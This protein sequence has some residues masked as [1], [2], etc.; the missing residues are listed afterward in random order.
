MTQRFTIGN[1]NVRNLVPAS[2]DEGYH[3]FY[4]ADKRNCYINQGSDKH[5]QYQ[6]KIAWLARQLD[7]LD[8]DIV[9]FEE[10]FE[11]QPLEDVVSASSYANKVKLYIC[12][13][14]VYRDETWEGKPARIHI[15]P[16]IALMV[17]NDFT[18]SAEKTIEK[19]SEQYDFSRGIREYSGRTWQ[20]QLTQGGKQINTFTHPVLRVV[21]KLPA[22]FNNVLGVNKGRP[23]IV[24][25]AAH[26]KSKRPIQADSRENDLLK[27]GRRYLGEHA[28][29]QARSLLVRAIEAAALRAYVL[30]DLGGKKDRPVFLLGDLNDGPRGITTDI[31]GGLAGKVIS[32]PGDRK[33]KQH[34]S[35]D[36]ALYSAYDLQT[37]KTHRD[38]YF[39]HIYEGFHDTLDHVMVSSHFVP[40]ALRNGLGKNNIGNV[41]TLRVLNDHLINA[42]VDDMRTDKVGK[43]MHTRSDHGQVSVRIDWFEKNT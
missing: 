35:A 30:E 3:F 4:G 36:L 1:F 31:A 14:S 24:L 18:V 9:C 43:Y 34:L 33:E 7:R 26:L 27:A 12:G 15:S 6:K 22:R 21:I 29:G 40:R 10:V 16:R 11:L 25:Y 42:V 20:L 41:G 37:Q 23:E 38:I 19:F 28:I 13:E 17:R 32:G 8:C 2:S 5:S 39:T